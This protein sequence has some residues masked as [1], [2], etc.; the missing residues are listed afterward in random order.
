[1]KSIKL[2]EASA[3]QRRLLLIGIP[4]FL[5]LAALLYFYFAGGR[6]SGRWAMYQAI[7]TDPATFARY[8]IK[9]GQR[10]GEAPFAFPTGGVILG[11]WDQSY[12]WGHR[13]AGIDI[14]S[15][16]QPGITPVYAAYPGYLT[17]LYDWRSTIIIRIPDDPLSPGRQ[18]WTYYTHLASVEG[19]S[20]I[21]A[22]FP[23]GTLEV[24][25]EAGTF[26]GYMGNFSGDPGNPTGLHLHFSVVKDDGD[27]EFLNELDIRNTFDPSPYFGLPL[28]HSNNPDEIPLCQSEIT[29]EDW[30]LVDASE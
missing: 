3:R 16:T 10:C 27:G 8:S 19:A 25:I 14:F 2:R 1:M 30:E 6:S 21:S 18:I 26:L 29:I 15:G 23:A 13:H 17:R 24:P 28:N 5:I 4:F 12:R 7:H 20:F 11:L 22:E 9:P